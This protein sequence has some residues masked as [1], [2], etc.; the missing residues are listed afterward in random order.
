MKKSTDEKGTTAAIRR[1]LIKAGAFAAAMWILTSF[2]YGLKRADGDS[3]AP[4][5]CRGDICIFTRLE[6]CSLE[7]VVVYRTETGIK[8]GRIVSIAGQT[9][10]FCDG[11]MTID[12]TVPVEMLPVKTYAA[13]KTETA[14]PVT[15][16][17]D[18]FFILNDDRRDTEDSRKSGPVKRR[19]IIGKVAYILKKGA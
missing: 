19:D 5:V 7:D 16:G 15:I 11:H 13:E 12:G 2:V 18:E 9:V 17:E 4:S 6:S 14:F 3:M 8:I 10:D 1:I